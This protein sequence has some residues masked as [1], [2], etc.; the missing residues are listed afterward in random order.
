MYDKQHN[1]KICV[2]EKD[3]KTYTLLKD[4]NKNRIDIKLKGENASD[5][6]TFNTKE[7]YDKFYN[8]KAMK[9]QISVDE[10]TFTK[11]NDLVKLTIVVQNLNIDKQNDQYDA[12]LLV[13]VQIK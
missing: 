13:F 3:G 6:F 1:Q 11:E 5:L 7:I 9:E 12:L 10:A 4:F 2:I 8:Y